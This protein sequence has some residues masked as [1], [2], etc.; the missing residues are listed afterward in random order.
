[1]DLAGQEGSLILG[2]TRKC[3]W[4]RM[5]KENP[6]R[7]PEQT[8]VTNGSVREHRMLTISHFT[9]VRQGKNPNQVDELQPVVGSTGTELL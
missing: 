3:L 8:S 6:D 4:E 2:N 1:M 9:L 7:N 5:D